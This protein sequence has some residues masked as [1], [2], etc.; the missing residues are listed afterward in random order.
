MS[1]DTDTGRVESIRR[2]E[3][4]NSFW[5]LLQLLC[6][7][8]S[9]LHQCRC[10]IIFFRKDIFTMADVKGFKAT[11]KAFCYFWHSQ[12][13]DRS[14]GNCNCNSSSFLILVLDSIFFLIIFCIPEE[15]TLWHM[16]KFR[17]PRVERQ[18]LVLVATLV[19]PGNLAA[20]S[21]SY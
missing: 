17:V 20:S 3:Q 21:S 11:F 9:R 16:C 10:F 15:L 19:P 6:Y 18:V 14:T 5:R 7:T 13:R 12:R 4:T 2:N 1:R 8:S